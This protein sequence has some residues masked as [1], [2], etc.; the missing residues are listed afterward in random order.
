MVSGEPTAFMARVLAA[1]FLHFHR[2]SEFSDGQSHPARGDDVGVSEASQR[3]LLP[4]S[5][6]RNEPRT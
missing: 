3:E 2:E 5:P 4:L 6:E 1:A